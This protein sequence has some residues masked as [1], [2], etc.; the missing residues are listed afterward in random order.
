MHVKTVQNGRVN[1]LLG[2]R[3]TSVGWTVFQVEIGQ[4]S[5]GFSVDIG[6]ANSHRLVHFKD[7]ALDNVQ[8]INCDPSKPVVQTNGSKSV[9]CTFESNENPLCGW[10]VTGLGSRSKW[11]RTNSIHREPGNDHT[12]LVIPKPKLSGTWITSQA[13]VDGRYETDYLMTKVPLKRGTFYCFSFWYFFFGIELD[14]SIALYA[15]KKAEA[16]ENPEKYKDFR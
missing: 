14:S 15:S 1:S 11:E 12:S 9:S 5:P 16:V 6:V 13:T 8:M 4:Q 7:A 3:R 2:E 10:D